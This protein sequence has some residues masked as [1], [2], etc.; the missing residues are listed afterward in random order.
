MELEVNLNIDKHAFKRVYRR[1]K[2]NLG[3][4]VEEHKKIVTACAIIVV[5]IIGFSIYK[6]QFITNKAYTQKDVY[7]AGVYTMKINNVYYTNKDQAGNIISNSSSFV[8]VELNIKNNYYEG[9]KVKL[10]RFHLY[11]GINKYVESSNQYSTSFNDLGQTY[12]QQTVLGSNKS[13]DIILIF[14]VDKDLRKNG[15]V[16]YYQE[17]GKKDPVLR[18]IKI[19]LRDVSTIK[20]NG[21]YKLGQEMK[22]PLPGGKEFENLAPDGFSI[23]DSTSYI[24]E[25]CSDNNCVQERQKLIPKAG[26]KIA[27]ISYMTEEF[28]SKDIIDF[29]SKYGKIN[30]IDSNNKKQSVKMERATEFTYLGQ[31]AYVEVPEE[32]EQSKTVELEYTIRN[33]RYTYKVRDRGDING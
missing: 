7:K 2:R 1:V 24:I 19:K 20:D 27:V 25:V 28:E 3:Y 23:K 11:N 6:Y 31:Y 22:C 33:N 12:T 32:I 15:F 30:Y 5:L 4:F 14:K 16:L 17:F 8:I 21:I 29:S 9:V 13:M 10:D 26:Y 18:K